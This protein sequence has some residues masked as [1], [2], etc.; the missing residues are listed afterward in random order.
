MQS[1][2][3]SVFTSDLITIEGPL[4]TREL[5]LIR[6]SLLYMLVYALPI[7]QEEILHGV[8]YS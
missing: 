5:Y 6:T 7:R 8:T 2:Y 3:D 4:A 1:N